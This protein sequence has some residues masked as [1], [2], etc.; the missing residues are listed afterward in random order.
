MQVLEIQQQT[1]EWFQA[2]KGK[3][4]ASHADCIGANGKGL[5]SYIIQIMSE[6]FS[7]AD[8]EIFSN[9]HTERGNELEATARN[10]Y[11]FETA[12]DVTEVGFI[13]FNDYVGCSPDGLVGQEGLIEIK[14]HSDPKF[15]KLLLDGE[16]E[17]KYIW[18][19]QMQMQIFLIVK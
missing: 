5:E 17:S 1:P 18:Q 13:I 11:E 12:Q 6:T 10:L 15:I 3:M 7:R 14:C 2:R 4:T 19:M 8:K 9:E 16:I